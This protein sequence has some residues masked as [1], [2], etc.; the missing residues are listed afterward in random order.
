MKAIV[1]KQYGLPDVLKLQE[2]P[3]PEP[4]ANDVL[5]KIMAASVNSWDWDMLRG[6]PVLYRLIF[7]LLRPKINILGCDIA[8]VVEAV[9]ENVQHLKPGDR[10]FGDVSADYW[11]GFAEYAKAK[12]KSLTKIPEGLSF[13][14]AAAIP[15]AGLL[16]FQG[17]KPLEDMRSGV[18][19]L[20]NGGGGGVGSFAIQIAKNAGHDVTGVDR[21]DKLAFMKS[22]G[23]NHVMDY[24]KEDFTRTGEKYDLIL[25]AVSS[26]S[27]T[28]YLRALN[29][30][31]QCV[32][33]G[34][35]VSS[36]IRAAL[37]GN[38]YKSF[39]KKRTSVLV[40]KPNEGIEG[41][42]ELI[43]KGEVRVSIDKVYKLQGTPEAVQHLGN[44]NML[45]KVII[46]MDT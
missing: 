9:G 37:L 8:G 41:L 6:K 16:A 11:G 40:H 31:G 38:V 24:E 3:I 15:Q 12:E 29:K 10:V 17:L 25:D 36:L 33:V 5:I 13:H 28:D 35:A 46:S 21:K 7:G 23:A 26:H 44:G 45:G 20:I 39:Y 22:L 14:E 2:I 43:I 1:Y 18:K 27:M 34:G 4:G 19:V 30:G 32:I 42:L